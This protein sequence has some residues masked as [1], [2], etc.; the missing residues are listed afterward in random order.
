M[1]AGQESSRRSGLQIGLAAGVLLVLLLGL[2]LGPEDLIQAQPS[3]I[4]KSLVFLL[5]SALTDPL[6]GT[7][8]APSPN[9]VVSP[10]LNPILRLAGPSETDHQMT[11]QIP[12]MDPVGSG[13]RAGVQEGIASG[14]EVTVVISQ[15]AGIRNPFEAGSYPVTVV[16]NPSASDASGVTVNA[17]PDI[18]GL[19]AEF[20]ITFTVN[21]DLPAN[22][23]SI[24]ITFDEDYLFPGEGAVT[25]GPADI[26][27]GSVDFPEKVRPGASFSYQLTVTN[28]GP[29]DATGV[30]LTEALGP[31]L[32]L[33]SVTASQGSCSE[34]AGRVSCVLGRITPEAIVV[35]VIEVRVKPSA[36]GALQANSSV[37]G[38]RADP[39]SGN[40]Q[41]HKGVSVTP[42]PTPTPPPTATPTPTSTPVPTPT[43]TAT[44]T[45][46]PT[47]VPTATAAPAPTATPVPVPTATSTPVPEPT[48]TP[49]VIATPVPP[50]PE[51]TAT[52]TP[53]PTRTPI[54][55]PAGTGGCSAPS[56]QV[57]VFE[58]G[59]ALLFLT[60]LG[61]T[62]VRRNR[63]AG[64]SSFC[65]K[66][67][68]IGGSTSS[69]RA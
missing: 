30:V 43:L 14:A 38:D 34:S 60:V 55:T 18:P 15:H 45:P 59:W 56:S 11:I 36:Q 13:P 19:G 62:L 17:S 25:P 63:K 49:V 6:N 53:E 1:N 33:E 61:V 35:L 21:S 46:T 37:G 22:A 57:E 26:S 40:N 39:V 27:L 64:C 3:N 5:A 68:K 32:A 7:A 2:A 47:P 48:A 23:G 24:V 67:R 51:P 44:P 20:R 58:G 65:Q 16:T 41:L 31:G 66:L 52:A 12:D 8:G 50:T 10:S 4:D 69:P 28:F 42:L 29:S 54:P 9:Q